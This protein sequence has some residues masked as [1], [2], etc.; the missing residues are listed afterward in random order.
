LLNQLA[1]PTVTGEPLR[2]LRAIEVLE[3]IGT[4]EARQF[5]ERLANGAPGDL[6]TLEARA[7]LG[8]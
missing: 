7:A 6:I 2:T 8:R 3:K 5:L 1:G 4:A